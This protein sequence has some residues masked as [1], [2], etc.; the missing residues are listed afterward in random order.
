ME[1]KDQLVDSIKQW[2][3]LD[4]E[5]NEN[6]KKIKDL[7]V[8]K[9][10]LSTS[11]LNTMKTNQIECFDIKDGALVYKQNK[12][13]K[14]INA[15]TLLNTLKTYY[16]KTPDKADEITKFILDN[17]EEQIRESLKRQIYK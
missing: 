7:N 5:I 10:M 13:K 12:V 15:K 8:K 1:T 14:P 2:I 9:K 6:K 3:L 11:L 4:N 16:N 17:R